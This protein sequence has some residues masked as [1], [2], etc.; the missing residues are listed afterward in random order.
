MVSNGTPRFDDLVEPPGEAADAVV[1]VG[2]V[3]DDIRSGADVLRGT[4]AGGRTAEVVPL[5]S[6]D[7]IRGVHVPGLAKGPQH[8]RVDFV[9]HLDG[10]RRRAGV[11]QR[12]QHFEGM[13]IHGVRHLLRARPAQAA[14]VPW[15][16]GSVQRSL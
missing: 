11:L 2:Q 15:A 5:R 3:Q 14:G 6:R 4:R 1:D 10:V 9:A 8:T 12:G 7:V 16:P 13:G